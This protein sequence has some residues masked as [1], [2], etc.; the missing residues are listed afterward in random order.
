MTKLLST[1]CLTAPPRVLHLD[2]E[3]Y[4]EEDLIKAGAHKYAMHE[5]TE[6]LNAGWAFDDDEP[7][8]WIPGMPCPPEI[9]EHV[10]NGGMVAAWNA[11]FERLMWQYVA[12]PKYGWLVPKLEQY[13]CIMVRAMAMNMPG[14]LENAAPAFGLP[15]RKDDVGA[16]TMKQLCKPRK[17]TKKNPDRRF[18]REKYPEKFAILDHYVLQDVRVEQGIYKRAIRLIPSERALWLLDQ[19][20]NDRGIMVDMELVEKARLIVEA[21]K[22]A[23]NIEMQN[24]TDFAVLTCD[25]VKQIKAFIVGRGFDI[26]GVDK[27]AL[28]NLLARDDLPPEV[29]R[30]TEIRLEAGKASVA[31]LDAFAR[32][33]C[34]DGTIKGTLQFHG[35]KQTGRWAARGVQVQNFPRPS[36]DT[37]ILLVIEDILN[38]LTSNREWIATMHGPPVSIISDILRGIL[39]ARPGRK[40]FS[41]DLSGIEARVLPWLAGA[42]DALEAFRTFDAGEG[43]DNYCHAAA[44]IYN[45]PVE[46]ITKA[47]R[48]VGKVAVLALGFGG[49]ASAFASMAKIYRVDLD[50]IFETVW[51]V[52]T[53]LNREKAEDGWK[54]R[55]CKSGIRKRAW[56]AAEMIKLAWR[57]ANPDIVQFW[58]DLE[59]AAINAIEN[60][61]QTFKA[62]EYITYRK[63]GS[64]LRCKLPSGRSIFYPYA[65]IE[66]ITT[67][68]GKQKKEIIFK[69]EDGFT[70]KWSEQKFYGGFGSENVTQAVARDVM[71][72]GLLAAEAG[73]YETLITIHD[74]D[75]AECDEALGSEEEFHELFVTPAPWAPGLPVT[76]TGWLDERYKKE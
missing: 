58:Y 59:N 1:T 55:G 31:K 15:I 53:L 12:G 66:W 69:S 30:C 20:I 48:Q 22:D 3:T 45:V 70:R 9:V 38:P 24:V 19:K 57:D 46:Q 2:Y 39:K 41:R 6:L 54:S 23:L 27:D 18:T 11:N 32:R 63:S 4:S 35:A 60:P 61:G 29:R 36:P 40:L 74:E 25:A 62:G 47:Q 44:R 17:T 71:V 16:R 76:A 56:L 34:T 50:A 51:G 37:D 75:V 67:P 5:S 73:G 68:W 21:E 13:D 14:K 64:F 7:V 26:K 42:E 28:T 49:G 33:I 52:T 43:Y 10:I 72:V 8:L 65:R